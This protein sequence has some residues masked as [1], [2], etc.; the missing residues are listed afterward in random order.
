MH[1][2]YRFEDMYI[3]TKK[4]VI[5]DE[6]HTFYRNFKYSINPEILFN[7]KYKFLRNEFHYL[8]IN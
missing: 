7:I 6:I 5:L 2:Y 4:N 1:K 3:F 8:S